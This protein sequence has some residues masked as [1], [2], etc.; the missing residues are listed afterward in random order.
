MYNRVVLNN[1]NNLI[2]EV[3]P[4]NRTKTED[5]AAMSPTSTSQG[6]Q[7]LYVDEAEEWPRCQLS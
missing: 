7:L 3:M 1:V 2:E 6:K 4:E 5:E